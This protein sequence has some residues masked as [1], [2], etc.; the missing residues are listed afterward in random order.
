MTVDNTL[1][2]GHLLDIFGPR[3]NQTYKLP[4]FSEKFRG[5]GNSFNQYLK[6][7]KAWEKVIVNGK[8]ISR[9]NWLLIYI[10]FIYVFVLFYAYH[11]GHIGINSNLSR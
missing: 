11:V 8:I 3:Q 10:F 7:Q 4:N 9:I 2:L 5:Q 1:I 6:K